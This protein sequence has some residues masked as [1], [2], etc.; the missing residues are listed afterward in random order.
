MP[1]A[2]QSWLGWPVLVAGGLFVGGRWRRRLHRRRGEFGVVDGDILLDLV[3]LNGEAVAGAGEG[4]AV[5][6]FYAVCVAVIG[7]VDLGGIAAQRSFRVANEA[8]QQ[9]GLLIEVKTQRWL[10]FVAAEDEIG[11]VAV[12]FFASDDG[13]FLEESLD[14]GG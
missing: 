14:V 13:E 6:D 5:G 2:N 12:D 3:D 7:V 1:Q 11:V 8:K 4:P 9:A 10:A